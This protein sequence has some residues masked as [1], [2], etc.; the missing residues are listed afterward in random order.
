MLQPNIFDHYMAVGYVSIPGEGVYFKKKPLSPLWTS[1]IMQVWRPTNQRLVEAHEKGK[2]VLDAKELA[3]ARAGRY[4]A[5]LSWSNEDANIECAKLFVAALRPLRINKKGEARIGT[6]WWPTTPSAIIAAIKEERE[7]AT[8]PYYEKAEVE[9][10]E[11][12]RSGKVQEDGWSAVA[13]T[14]RARQPKTVAAA[15]AVEGTAAAAAGKKRKRG[16]GAATK[17]EQRKRGG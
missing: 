4:L 14:G 1:F 8:R 6:A 17:V 3:Q 7:K 9:A 13:T 12:L 5:P 10:S 2:E 11:A 15:A 16:S